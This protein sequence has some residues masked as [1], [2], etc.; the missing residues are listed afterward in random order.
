M[1][2]TKLVQGT[3]GQ[4]DLDEKI[5]KEIEYLSSFTYNKVIDVK[6]IDYYTALIV[7]EEV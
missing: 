1:L 5:N 2:K 3:L 6:P 4:Y 7:Y